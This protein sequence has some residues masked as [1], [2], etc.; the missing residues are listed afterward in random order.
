MRNDGNV[1]RNASGLIAMLAFAGLALLTG[2]GGHTK[3]MEVPVQPA[4]APTTQ[5]QR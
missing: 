4:Q 1:M 2:C 5:P 3:V